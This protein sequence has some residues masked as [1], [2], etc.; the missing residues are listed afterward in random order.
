MCAPVAEAVAERMIVKRIVLPKS[1]PA[2]TAVCGHVD[3]VANSKPE[4]KFSD[5]EATDSMT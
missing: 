2:G 1:T 4:T 5:P 3:S